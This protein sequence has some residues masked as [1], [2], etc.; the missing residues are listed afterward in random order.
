MDSQLFS[1]KKLPVS[2]CYICSCDIAQGGDPGE[3]CN[4]IRSAVAY[5]GGENA[6]I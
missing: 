1:N 3:I 6:E 5:G 2:H 4:G